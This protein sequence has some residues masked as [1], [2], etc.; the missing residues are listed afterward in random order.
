MLLGSRARPVRRAVNLIAVCQIVKSM[1]DP[2]RLTTLQA[3]KV[4]Y[5]DS[6]TFYFSLLKREL[7]INLQGS[8]LVLYFSI[9]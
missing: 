6:F 3:S 7:E 4:C 8:Y 2:Q 5:G 9:K 1:C